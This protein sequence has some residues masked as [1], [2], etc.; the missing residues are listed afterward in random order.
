MLPYFV[1]DA[2]A[3]VLANFLEGSVAVDEGHGVVDVVLFFELGEEPFG[4]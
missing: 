4:G 3:V 2:E 1:A